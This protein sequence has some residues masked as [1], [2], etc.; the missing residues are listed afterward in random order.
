MFSLARYRRRF[1]NL[2]SLNYRFAP[3]DWRLDYATQ[4]KAESEYP[5]HVKEQC[6]ALAGDYLTKLEESDSQSMY[7]FI[8]SE[9]CLSI[10]DSIFEK[11]IGVNPIAEV[12]HGNWHERNRRIVAN[13]LATTGE[14]RRIVFVFGSDHLPQ[15][16]RQLKALGMEAQTLFFCS[17]SRKYPDK[18][19]RILPHGSQ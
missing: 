8:H 12:A 1:L 16:Q 7:D 14:A 6:S 18:L 9:I 19:I 2:L 13:G 5:V 3:V 4:S 17:F 10:I 15:L 11:I